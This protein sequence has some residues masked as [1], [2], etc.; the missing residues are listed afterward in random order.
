MKNHLVRGAAAPNDRTD[1]MEAEL[2]KWLGGLEPTGTPIALRFRT[3]ADLREEAARP[4]PRLPWLR[5]ALSSMASLGSVVAGAGLL[6]LLA[7]I[8]ASAQL[9]GAVAGSYGSQLSGAGVGVQSPMGGDYTYGPDPIA[10][11]WLV[12]ASVLAGCTVLIPRVRR[13]VGRIAFGKSAAAPG[14]PLPFRRSWRSVPPI[15]WILGAIAVGLCSWGLRNFLT[16]QVDPY[17]F[18]LAFNG[19]ITGTIAV[20]LPVAVAWRY[21]LRDRSARLLLVGLL[22]MIA[23]L[24]FDV[25]LYLL[26]ILPVANELLMVTW[27]VVWIIAGITLA[28]GIAGRAGAVR[29]PSLRL[30]APAVGAAFMY[31][32]ITLFMYGVGNTQPQYL[33]ENLAIY[34]TV[35]VVEVAWVAIVWVGIVAWRRGRGSWAWKLVL[36]AGVLHFLNLVPNFLDQILQ[37]LDPTRTGFG[38]LGSWGVVTYAT[39]DGSTAIVAPEVWWAMITNAASQIALLLALLIGLRPTSP[40]PVPPMPEPAD[41]ELDDAE[42]ATTNPSTEPSAN[43]A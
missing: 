25:V 1:R 29:R 2:T 32:T 27:E 38:I 15:A 17:F 6:V 35:W 34:F 41:A 24:F 12:F 26:G 20:F 9:S 33:I 22:A 14:A 30:A 23:N 11:L 40:K 39:P 3:F 42:S 21:P 43:P 37:F 31:A 16:N 10:I 8:G 36:A 4:R 5:P 13:I 18:I 28:A 7:I 19:I